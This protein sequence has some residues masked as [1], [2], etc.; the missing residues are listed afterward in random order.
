VQYN[1]NVKG[2]LS[3]GLAWLYTEGNQI[4]RSDTGEATLLK[5]VNRSGLEYSAPEHGGFLEAA[6]L[7]CAD[8]ETIIVGWGCNVIRVPFNQEWILR[9]CGAHSAESYRSALD[10]VIE[11]AATL[12]AYTILDLQWLSNET[13]YGHLNDGS[14]NY[15]PPLPNPE[16]IATWQLLAERYCDE[17]AA[18]FDLFNEP[19]DRLADDPNPLWI[20]DERGQPHES[21]G[22]RVGSD[23][24]VNWARRLIDTIHA[25]SPRTQTLV[26]GVQWGYDLRGVEIESASI[27]YSAH[28]YPDRPHWQW[29]DRFGFAGI[30]RPLFIG[31]W[32]GGD[33]DVEWGARLLNFIQGRTCGWTAWSWVDH[34]H[35]VQN[36]R[37][38]DYTP[39]R[40]GELVRLAMQPDPT[41]DPS[42]L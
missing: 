15:V 25:T 5:G 27:I 34:P 17:P 6:G 33:E 30:D 10:Q 3:H 19:H 32:G 11:W 9:G 39:T 4:R 37:N 2:E 31:E 1:R 13:V 28:I 14:A 12:G 38:G 21:D 22:Y 20:V 24:W 40:F 8:L 36:A 23:Q 18:L 35:L 42:G 29:R 41:S 26:S 7:T 16:S